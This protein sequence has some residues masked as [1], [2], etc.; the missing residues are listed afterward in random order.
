VYCKLIILHLLEIPVLSG[1]TVDILKFLNIQILNTVKVICILTNLLLKSALSYSLAASLPALSDLGHNILFQQ[2][3]RP[4]NTFYF[5]AL[6]NKYESSSNLFE[7]PFKA[8]HSTD[9]L[10]QE[11]WM[12]KILV[13]NPHNI[14]IIM[15]VDT[16][17]LNIRNS[18][19]DIWGNQHEK[20][21]IFNVL[22]FNS[23]ILINLWGA[24]HVLHYSEGIY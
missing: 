13:S 8:W 20:A 16:R 14:I 15:G 22:C 6:N 4:H 11:Q 10:G 3:F 24:I 2:G 21:Y 1:F 17:T 5:S 7:F 12:V 9:I 19:A 18:W 23:R